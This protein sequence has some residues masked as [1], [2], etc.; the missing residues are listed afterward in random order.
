MNLTIL[1]KNILARKKKGTSISSGV[2]PS[3]LVLESELTDK[4]RKLESYTNSNEKNR[5]EGAVGYEYAITGV[6]LIDT[7]Y[8]SNPIVGDYKHV[9]TATRSNIKPVYVGSKNEKVKFELQI[10]DKK[11]TTKLYKTEDISKE[12]LY[13][14]AAQFH[15]HPKYIHTQAI[16]QYSFFSPQDIASLVSGS[17]YILGLVVG[18]ELWIAGKT[19]QSRMIPNTILAHAS[20]LEALQGNESVVSFLRSQSIKDYGIVLYFGKLGGSL[21]KV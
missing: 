13:G 5:T 11:V 12:L 1:C 17:G 9:S 15:T 2:Y 6:F 10:N 4:L 19:D 7:L 20:K 21:T 14:I 18:R 16:S 8:Y 3:K